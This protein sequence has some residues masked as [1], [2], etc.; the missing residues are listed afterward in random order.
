M[1]EYEVTYDQETGQWIYI[2]PQG[3]QHLLDSGYVSISPTTGKYIINPS[4]IESVDDTGG[5]VLGN[6]Q[7]PNANSPGVATKFGTMEE[8]AAKYPY[9]QYEIKVG[10]TSYGYYYYP[11]PNYEYLSA[12]TGGAGRAE[13]IAYYNATTGKQQT[14]DRQFQQKQGEQQAQQQQAELALQKQ[15]YV[16]N[17][18]ANPGSWI[19]AWYASQTPQR[20]QTNGQDTIDML[21][22]Y[23]QNDPE[24]NAYKAYAADFPASGNTVTSGQ[25]PQEVQNG[26]A[27]ANSY[28][29]AIAGVQSAMAE[30]QP[31]FRRFTPQAPKA[32]NWLAQYAPGVGTTGARSDR[33]A[34]YGEITN[35]EVPTLSGQQ[36]Q[37]IDPSKLAGLQSYMTWAGQNPDDMLAST[38]RMLPES[39]TGAGSERWAATKQRR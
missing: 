2:D 10:Q 16:A 11:T 39:P 24:I 26:V 35:V 19:E 23:A 37:A 20:Q 6:G 4:I 27:L 33:A 13:D 30:K 32:P 36:Y 31:S 38:K 14:A 18:K 5:G 21:N 17:L 8:A 1:K 9:P 34:K 29:D 7:D 22:T 3:Q 28:D 25:V 12:Q 15:Q